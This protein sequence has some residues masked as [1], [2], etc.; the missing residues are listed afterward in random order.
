M[1]N[2]TCSPGTPRFTL[3]FAPGFDMFPGTPPNRSNRVVLMVLAMR[4]RVPLTFLIVG[5]GN[6]S[7]TLRR[8][9]AGSPLLALLQLFRCRR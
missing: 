5:F 3:D 6:G 2:M 1:R 9:R 7:W 4:Y 8:L